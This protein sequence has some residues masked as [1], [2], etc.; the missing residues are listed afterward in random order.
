M[1][2]RLAL[3]HTSEG[4]TVTLLFIGTARREDKRTA[5]CEQDAPIQSKLSKMATGGSM[6]IQCL[7][8]ASEALGHCNEI[9]GRLIPPSPLPFIPTTR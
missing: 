9:V 1:L 2:G 7:C 6:V 5:A 8:A 4:I 3:Q